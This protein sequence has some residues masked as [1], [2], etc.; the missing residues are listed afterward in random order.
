MDFVLLFLC[1]RL[2]FFLRSLV[3]SGVRTSPGARGHAPQRSGAPPRPPP[4]RGAPWPGLGGKREPSRRRW[5]NATGAKARAA[6]SRLAWPWAGGGGGGQ[7]HGSR[8]DS[9]AP[10]HARAN[11]EINKCHTRSLKPQEN[12]T[13]AERGHNGHRS[14]RYTLAR[15]CTHRCTLRIDTTQT[16]K[17][18][19]THSAAQGDVGAHSDHPSVTLCSA[20]RKGTCLVSPAGTAM[21]RYTAIKLSTSD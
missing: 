15:E 11:T 12:T 3:A 18:A 9:G 14:D 2:R 21:A 1:F 5:Q 16:H 13:L 19:C 17:P 4:P 8:R 6:C 10:R 20:A 7:A